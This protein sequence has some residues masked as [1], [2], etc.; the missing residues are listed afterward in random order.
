MSVLVEFVKF[1]LSFHNQGTKSF[2]IPKKNFHFIGTFSATIS[3]GHPLFTS[4]LSK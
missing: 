3:S 4:Q 2:Q 1:L